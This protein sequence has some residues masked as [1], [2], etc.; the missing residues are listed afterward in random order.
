MV[1]PSVCRRRA[2]ACMRCKRSSDS[3]ACDPGQ[4]EPS[5]VCET[6]IAK[7]RSL[8]RVLSH[9]PNTTL[10]PT[11]HPSATIIWTTFKKFVAYA[12]RKQISS[13]RLTSFA[14]RG[15]EHVGCSK[16]TLAAGIQSTAIGG[17]QGPPQRPA[18]LP[19]P[20]IDSRWAFGLN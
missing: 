18:K 1:A 20:F 17:T 10:R 8:Y 4:R 2:P 6:I 14:S 16:D 3:V 13:R 15:R 5:D 11:K 7:L 9:S 12:H 19:A